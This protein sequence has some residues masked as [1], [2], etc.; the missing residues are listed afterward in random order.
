MAVEWLALAA[1]ILI[2]VFWE[3]LP[4]FASLGIRRLAKMDVG[5]IAAIVVLTIAV[6]GFLAH[7]PPKMPRAGNMLAQALA[8][9]FWLRVAL[10]LTAG[11]CEELFFRGYAIE[12]LRGLT[13]NT[14]IGALLGTVLFTLG[15]IPRYGLSSGLLGVA[16]IGALLSAIYVWRRNLFPCIAL[17]WFFDAISLLAIPSFAVFIG[18]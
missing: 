18:K 7:S 1:L 11:I 4:L 3:R 16:F 17:H 5:I 6:V 13:G 8:V 9:P 2:V 15:H 12:R 14:W 10:V